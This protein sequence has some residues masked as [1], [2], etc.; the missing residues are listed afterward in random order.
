MRSF[1]SSDH[2]IPYPGQRKLLYNQ[3]YFLSFIFMYGSIFA[4]D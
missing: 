4:F 2:V 3:K 1:Y